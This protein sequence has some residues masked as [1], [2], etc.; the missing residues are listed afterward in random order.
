MS[1]EQIRWKYNPPKT[2]SREGGQPPEPS[3]PVSR[4]DPFAGTPRIRSLLERI[5]DLK[6]T[7]A[8]LEQAILERSRNFGV[9]LSPSDPE[10]GMSLARIYDTEDPPGVVTM[11]MFSRIL[12]AEIGSFRMQG[13]LEDAGS[14]R[15]VSP[16][17]QADLMRVSSEVEKALAESA[18]PDRMLPL[19]L[20]NLKG[21]QVIFDDL[22]LE[23]SR[24]L[25]P[26][27]D[28]AAQEAPPMEAFAPEEMPLS[29]LID[30]SK[31]AVSEQ[32]EPE[33][34]F[35]GYRGYDE[36]TSVADEPQ[37]PPQEPEPEPE[38]A[39]PPVQYDISEQNYNAINDR[40]SA[41]EEFYGE[42][43]DLA[44]G[45]DDV[46]RTARYFIDAYFAYPVEQLIYL[47]AW[48]EASILI[49]AKTKIKTLIRGLA[50]FLYVRLIG[51]LFRSMWLVERLLRRATDPYFRI[52]NSLSKVLA[53]PAYA[54]SRYERI[55]RMSRMSKTTSKIFDPLPEIPPEARKTL[56]EL[57]ASMYYLGKHLAEAAN[58]LPRKLK[59]LQLSFYKALDRRIGSGRDQAEAMRSIRTALS[60]IALIRSLIV[61]KQQQEAR[62]Q[63]SG[64]AAAPEQ[65]P[66]PA[67]PAADLPPMPENVA[68]VL[69][70]GGA[71]L[72]EALVQ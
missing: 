11:D 70:R 34:L 56:Q 26:L 5:S 47:I 63:S 15:I 59:K 36:D 6:D 24:G 29:Q 46:A 71:S 23:L 30:T 1:F 35:D 19:F 31:W 55:R 58:Y 65:V 64:Q 21:D 51:D 12:D 22:L 37:D 53:I 8:W 69:E 33:P 72:G 2:I 44:A 20:R 7:A 49:L 32:K 62:R 60:L 9:A 14:T 50:R 18:D 25:A 42:L 28:E 45:I 68:G 10:L 39:L 61:W 67:Q 43:Y 4:T 27:E 38:Y 57:P 41:W 3:A 13:A 54:V 48:L 52:L 17:Q 66:G 40:L 16:V